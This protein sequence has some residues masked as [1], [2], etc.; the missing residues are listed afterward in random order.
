M[1]DLK[2]DGRTVRLP[3][4]LTISNQPMKQT[5]HHPFAL[6]QR[7]TLRVAAL[8]LTAVVVLLLVSVLAI[9]CTD[10]ASDGSRCG[11]ASSGYSLAGDAVSAPSG[12]GC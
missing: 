3:L 12:S 6:P 10:G 7:G 2:N 5:L 1:Y 11:T 8:L 9:A 4:Q